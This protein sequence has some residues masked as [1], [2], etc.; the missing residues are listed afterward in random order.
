MIKKLSFMLAVSGALFLTSCG[1]GE[2]KTGENESEDGATV[3]TMTINEAD[4]VATDF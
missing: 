4:W 1:G 3:P 2:S